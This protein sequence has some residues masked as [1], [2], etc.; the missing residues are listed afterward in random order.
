MDLSAALN[1]IS[2]LRNLVEVKEEEIRQLRDASKVHYDWP[3]E[4]GLTP[5]E[6]RIL[7]RLVNVAPGVITRE[8]M[9]IFMHGISD[10]RTC[11]KT[12]D[13]HIL[14]LRRKTEHLGVKINSR[15]NEGYSMPASSAEILRRL[16]CDRHSSHSAATFLSL[17]SSSVR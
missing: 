14:R 16:A 10:T 5:M 6:S 8:R 9:S 3:A 2:R 1:E 7:T 11:D 13:V 17:S 15:Y 4:L 12:F